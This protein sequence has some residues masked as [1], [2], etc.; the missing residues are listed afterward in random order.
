MH[1]F[2]MIFS[3]SVDTR[4]LQPGTMFVA[5]PGAQVDGHAYIQQA[6]QKNA[7]GILMAVSKKDL[8]AGLDQ[9][10][11]K[12]K[13][14]ILVNDP[15]QAFIK[16]ACAWRD[17]FTYPV[18]GITGSVGKTSTKE[19]LKTI[20]RVNGTRFVAIREQS[21]YTRWHCHEYF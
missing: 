18:V 21:K 5:L 12:N 7:A 17:Q 2:L 3:F 11:L 10:V 9:N 1:Y 15:L 4:T 16:L 8:L 6:L 13:L 14:I 19:I 20:L